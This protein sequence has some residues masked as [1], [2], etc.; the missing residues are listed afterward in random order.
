MTNPFKYFRQC[1]RLKCILKINLLVFQSLHKIFELFRIK[2]GKQDYS[3][4]S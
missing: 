3:F 1:D 2:N 4:F